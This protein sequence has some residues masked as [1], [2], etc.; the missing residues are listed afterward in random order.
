MSDLTDE[1]LGALETTAQWLQNK[2]PV[3][4]LSHNDE[5]RVGR[6]IEAALIELRRHRSAQAADRERV[7]STVIATLSEADSW[8]RVDGF[9]E[10]FADR[11]ANQLATPV[12]TRD[13]YDARTGTTRHTVPDQP[14]TAPVLSKEERIVL[15]D[16]RAEIGPSRLGPTGREPLRLVLD[17][18][19]GGKP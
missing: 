3:A 8:S 5:A 9:V 19:L 16:L 2:S 1:E 4:Q 11:V 14:E 7:R 15:E 17:R 12:E 6:R 18:M 10:R 13:Q